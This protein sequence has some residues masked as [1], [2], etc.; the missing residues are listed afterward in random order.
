MMIGGHILVSRRDVEAFCPQAA[1]RPT[2]GEQRE[3]ERIKAILDSCD[4]ALR[5]RVYLYLQ[6]GRSPHPIEVQL[7]TSAEV[8]LDALGRA[9][10]LTTR[11]FRGMIAEAAFDIDVVRC[12]S[13]WKSEPMEG[14]LSYDFR[15][16]D[17]LGTLRIQVKLQRSVRQQ[18]L[19]AAGFYVVETQRTRGGLDRS[20]G[21][22]TRPYRFEEFDI[23][24]V[25]MQPSCG[26]WDRFYYTVTSWL[27][28]ARTEPGLIATLQPVAPEPNCD[29]TDDFGTA[30]TWFRE[31]T[32]KTIQGKLSSPRTGKGRPPG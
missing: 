25:C 22:P 19:M 28:P 27:Q 12:L 30:I 10:E 24:A 4:P 13:G 14:N 20:T 2:A 32:K 17:K 7:G 16:A 5:E 8:I 31:G 3:F 1:G 6:S 21:G 26:R 23:L 29:W 9:A 18:P 11:M 15:L